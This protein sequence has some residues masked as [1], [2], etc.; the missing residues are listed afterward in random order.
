MV[1]DPRLPDRFSSAE[2][3]WFVKRPCGGKQRLRI[4]ARDGLH[5]L[6]K[7]SASLCQMSPLDWRPS[8]VEK[9]LDPKIPVIGRGQKYHR[10]HHV[11]SIH[12]LGRKLARR[13]TL[14]TQSIVSSTAWQREDWECELRLLPGTAK[15]AQQYGI[16]TFSSAVRHLRHLNRQLRMRKLGF[17]DWAD[18]TMSMCLSQG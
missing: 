1:N 6:E 5:G 10:G 15:A 16:D 13:G 4:L 7:H 17:V 3:R 8:V 11:R 2:C 12:V 14:S 18:F 9:A